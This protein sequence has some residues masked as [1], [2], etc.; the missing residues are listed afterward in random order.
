MEMTGLKPARNAHRA[1]L[2]V[3]AILIVDWRFLAVI[4]YFVWLLFN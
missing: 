3:S 4:L 2:G 1:L